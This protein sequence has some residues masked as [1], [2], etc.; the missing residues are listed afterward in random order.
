MA[1]DTVRIAAVGDVHYGKQ[2]Q[3]PLRDLFASVADRAQVLL[4]CGDL[5]DHGL[6]EEAQALARD[7][8]ATRVPI[9]AVLG[10]HDFEA[11]KQDEVRKILLDAGVCVLDGESCEF[12]GIG[13]AG[14]K[15]FCG[16][17]GPRALAPWGE[18]IIKRFVHEAIEEALKLESAL[19]RLTT[20]HRV[21]VLHYSPIQTTVEGEPCEIFAFLG[22]SRLE[23]PLTR[24]P[25][26]VV[27]HGHA[28]RGTPEGRTRSGAP[29][30]NVSRPL[31]ESAFPGAPA[32]RIVE[33]GG[34]GVDVVARTDRADDG[35]RDQPAEGADAPA[36]RSDGRAQRENQSDAHAAAVEAAGRG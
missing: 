24:Y 9:I 33:V 7:L 28:H 29:V 8:A 21:A 34:A 12:H 31:L 6:P 10:N 13:F 36:G 3:P 19:M 30:Y 1:T 2:G 5:T 26:D 11:G 32:L 4:V 35:A 22:S 15:G 27:F 25:V 17:F 20:E 16:G 14:V 18:D 23:E